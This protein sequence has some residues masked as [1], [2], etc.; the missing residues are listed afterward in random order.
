MGLFRT[1]LPR[2]LAHAPPRMK[3][4]DVMASPAPAIRYAI[5]AQPFMD[6]D[7]LAGALSA[8]GCGKPVLHLGGPQVLFARHRAAAEFEPLQWWKMLLRTQGAAG[9]FATTWLWPN[10]AAIFGCLGTAETEFL[11]RQI[12]K[13]ALLRIKR[14]DLLPTAVAQHLAEFRAQDA[15]TVSPTED[16]L[17]RL[18]KLHADE[19]AMDNWLQQV[20]VVPLVI[21]YD[22]LSATPGETALIAARHIG[23]KPSAATPAA[24]APRPPASAQFVRL[25][26]MARQA[27]GQVR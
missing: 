24:Q 4:A 17:R 18:E 26:E 1:L 9:V 25:V 5:L 16:I 12:G 2:L 7:V 6:A 10:L 27:D 8:L 3:M 19:A 11:L 15:N 22:E 13:F 20:G 14:K 21:D 23:I